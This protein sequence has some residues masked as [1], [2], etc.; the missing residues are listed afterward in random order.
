[1]KVQQ[2]SPTTKTQAIQA[3]T[4]LHGNR[5]CRH[6]LR[7]RPP[8][9]HR[10]Q[11]ASRPLGEAL[12]RTPVTPH[13]LVQLG[14]ESEKRNE[15]LS[16]GHAVIT[17]RVHHLQTSCDFGCTCGKRGVLL[18][19]SVRLLYAAISWRVSG[20]LIARSIS[21]TTRAHSH[22]ARRR[23]CYQPP[24]DLLPRGSP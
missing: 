3:C 15:S 14:S 16:G 17:H 22:S 10:H 23:G 2:P 24:F 18:A 19:L 4:H 1:M 20:I 11:S 9:T 13:E 5:M 8:G 6:E 21:T 12:Q 7:H